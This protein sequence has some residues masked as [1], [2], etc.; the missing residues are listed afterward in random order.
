MGGELWTSNGTEAGTSPVP[1]TNG[2]APSELT[3][4]NG[5]LYFVGT[6]PLY[7]RELF[8]FDGVSALR[9]SDINLG[10]ADA[11][12][13]S[14]TS[15]GST[16]FF[17]AVSDTAGQPL[18]RELWKVTGI[19]DRAGEGHPAWRRQLRAVLADARRDDPVL[20]RR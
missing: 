13:R 20:C 8:R 10:A 15:V 16:L 12:P 5:T 11:D 3:D 2:L 9:V 7:G 19:D 14:L 6:D 1:G 4:V 18:G 17:T